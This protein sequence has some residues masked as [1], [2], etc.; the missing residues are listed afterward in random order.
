MTMTAEVQTPT[1][2]YL[3]SLEPLQVRVGYGHLGLRGELGYENKRVSVHRRQYDHALSAHPPARILFHLGGRYST[4]RCE[5][6]LNDDVPAGA[7]HADFLVFAD[8]RQVGAASF[9]QAGRPPQSLISSISGAQLLELV[10]QSSRW[11]YCHSVWL[12]PRLESDAGQSDITVLP[13]CLG[14]AQISLPNPR[15]HARR[16]IATVLS[17]GFESLADDM[18][19][20]LYAN[21]ECR[22]AITV[23]FLLGESDPCARVIAKYKGI[24]V[25][26]RPIA[27]INPMSK[28][29]VYSVAR[30][31]DAEQFLCLD[32]DMV[33]LG[34]LLPVFATLEACPEGALLAVREGNGQGLQTLAHAFLQ[35]YGGSERDR[36]KFFDAPD[37]AAYPLVVND[38]LFAGT[39]AALLALDGVIRSLPELSQWLDQRSDIWWRNQFAFNLALAK[40]RCGVELDGSYNVQLHAQDVQL[41][42]CPSGVHAAWRGRPVRVLH[43]SGVGRRKYPES[44]GHYALVTDPLVGAGGGTGYEDF[45]KALR[46]WVG[47]HGISALAWS[48]YGTSDARGARVKDPDVFPLFAALHYLVRSNGCVRVLECGTA[49]GV[50]AAC[51]ASAVAHREGARLVTF[52]PFPQPEREEL[53]AALPAS[54]RACIEPRT[55]GSLEGMAEA[56]ERNE[57]FDA[58]LLDSIH[59]VEHVWQ[60]FRLAA[61]LVCQSGLIIIHDPQFIGGTVQLALERIESEGYGVTRLWCASGGVS[62]DDGL[63]LALIENRCKSNK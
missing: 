17:P 2:C 9:V 53:W 13:D 27:A 63:G 28:A 40:F 4:F 38:G 50:S 7:S 20:S 55:V 29:V 21:G 18:L 3:D 58:A 57:S 44:M 25:P 15:P 12:D 34:S 1:P 54:M 59:T 47:R 16:C 48:F 5:V 39:R 30:V 31:V 11:E 62:E 19:G 43:R 8:S 52:D 56:I 22:D 14:R 61:R 37:E 45:L 41:S 42:H 36:Q 51:L 60:E 35:V 33:V 32:S 24:L 6:A 46:G 23:A 10:V 49:K 26:C